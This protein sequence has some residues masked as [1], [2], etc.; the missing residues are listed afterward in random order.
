VGANVIKKMN[1]FKLNF[2]HLPLHR[3]LSTDIL[4]FGN[5]LISEDYTQVVFKP[6]QIV[7]WEKKAD[8]EGYVIDVKESFLDFTI[9]SASAIDYSFLYNEQPIHINLTKSDFQFLSQ[10]YE[11]IYKEY[12]IIN[13]ESIVTIKNLLNV[14]FVQLRRLNENP[15]K[16]HVL[17]L[18]QPIDLTYFEFASNYR[19][20]V[21]RDYM[22]SKSVTFYADKLNITTE[23]LN[24]CV[25]KTY[26]KTAK[27]VIND[28]LMLH[29]KTLLLQTSIQIKD[30]AY[31][32]NFDD[33]SHFVKFF[34]SQTG[35]SPADF[36]LKNSV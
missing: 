3:S 29:I 1:P 16:T 4:L 15:S 17:Q 12:Q 32:L 21:I 6:G 7:S 11:M 23:F 14:L 2:F 36:R 13:T 10:I 18:V 35:I 25:K 31:E 5:K 22:K 30:L 33:Y 34:K 9:A 27:D 19:S 20:M 26:Q 28:V 24:K 8:W